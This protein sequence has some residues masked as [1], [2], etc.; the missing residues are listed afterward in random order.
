MGCGPP[1]LAPQ[2]SGPWPAAACFSPQPA[3]TIQWHEGALCSSPPHETRAFPVVLWFT[4][5]VSHFWS[6][7]SSP[8]LS[9]G[10]LAVSSLVHTSACFVFFIATSSGGICGLFFCPTPRPL[11]RKWVCETRTVSYLL[12]I[13]YW[14]RS[15][16]QDNMSHMKSQGDT[17][18]HSCISALCVHVW[19][20][21]NL[22]LLY[23][24]HVL[25]V[26]WRYREIHPSIHYL[27]RCYWNQIQ[28][29]LR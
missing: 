25:V 2:C 11:T 21:L 26:G 12:T 14:E 4:Y 20:S 18:V 5:P 24:A 17:V 27:K 8:S 10:A 1:L 22:L 3:F 9:H 13:D 28:L 7:L 16:A 29:H 23:W 6:P 15:G 19:V